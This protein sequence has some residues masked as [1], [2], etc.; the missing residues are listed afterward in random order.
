[1]PVIRALAG[2][3]G[4]K[5]TLAP[6]I[7]EQLGRHDSYWEPFAGSCAVL[8]NKPPVSHESINDLHEELM[9]L[10]LV[11][12]DRDKAADLYDRVDRVVCH[13]GM[14]ELAREHVR[15]TEDEPPTADVTRAYWYFTFSR[16][17]R[18]GVAGTPLGTAGGFAK[19]F[20][21]GGDVTTRFRS[22]VESIPF[23]HRRL[24]DAEI[25]W[26]CG[27][28]LLA[29]VK[30]RPGTSLFI[31]PPYVQK[32]SRYEHDFE[33]QDHHRLAELLRRFRRARVV[34]SY[35]SH[36]LVNE[37]YRDWGRLDSDQLGVQ[38]KMLSAGMRDR[39]GVTQAP[40]VLLVNGEIFGRQGE[41]F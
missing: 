16:L 39:T 41:L 33:P 40:E 11:L 18:S 31:D 29:K 3:Y 30:D 6:R 34:L 23:W 7:I 10:V 15:R 12:A 37:L 28:E 1:M 14:M 13:Q 5:T 35:Y 26:G 20:S 2:W 8:L 21:P 25:T 27:F 4:A 17:H 38:K 32:G 9:N 36:P 22:A 19:R 24:Q